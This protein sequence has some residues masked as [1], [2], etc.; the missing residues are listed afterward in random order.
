M[1]IQKVGREMLAQ[2]SNTSSSRR[3]GTHRLDA[4]LSRVLDVLRRIW[5]ALKERFA[6]PT[7]IPM[8]IRV[9]RGR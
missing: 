1:P 3:G 2:A 8:P 9:D 7:R 5:T 4:T 6:P